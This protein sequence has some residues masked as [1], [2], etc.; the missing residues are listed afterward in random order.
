MGR[1][2]WWHSCRGPPDA[3]DAYRQC[4]SALWPPDSAQSTLKP[5]VSRLGSS[6]RVVDPAWGHFFAATR[7][8]IPFYKRVWCSGR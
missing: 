6:E 2:L 1:Q 4:M 5:F 3:K 8:T 7:Y